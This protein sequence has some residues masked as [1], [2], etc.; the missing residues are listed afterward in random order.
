LIGITLG[1]Q[2]WRIIKHYQENSP[3]K[4][5]KEERFETGCAN[6]KPVKPVK[7]TDRHA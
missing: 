1:T 7:T 5:K 2:I 6:K 3:F 4:G